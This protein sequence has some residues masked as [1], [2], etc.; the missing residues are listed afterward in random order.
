MTENKKELLESLQLSNSDD[1]HRP[2]LVPCS[3]WVE[4]DEVQSLPTPF[5][6]T[7]VLIS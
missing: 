4:G 2:V 7:S 3:A 1:R 5:R 6:K